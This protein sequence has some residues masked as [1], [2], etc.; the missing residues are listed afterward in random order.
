MS[1]LRLFS[2]EKAREI[3]ALQSRIT[4]EKRPNVREALIETQR[5][6]WDDLFPGQP[7]EAILEVATAH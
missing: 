2:V 4:S 7:I 1:M 6:M 3:V 5:C